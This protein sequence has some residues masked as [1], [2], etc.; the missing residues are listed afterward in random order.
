MSIP[1]S[2]FLNNIKIKLH[3]VFG[4]A[5][6]NASVFM[7][8]GIPPLVLSEI[9]SLNPLS[10]SIPEEYGGRGGKT[11]EIL[12]LLSADF[13]RIIATLGLQ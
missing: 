3:D 12:A 2:D 11:E 7:N 4:D 8:K 5:K 1:F 13:I 10:V 9:M 6:I